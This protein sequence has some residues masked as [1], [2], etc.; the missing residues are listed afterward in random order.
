MPTSLL[1][2]KSAADTIKKMLP[3]AFAITGFLAFSYFIMILFVELFSMIF[4]QSAVANVVSYAISFIIS[5]F[6]T[7]PITLGIMR[8]FW[9]LTSGA[10]DSLLSCFYY[11]SSIE[12]YRISLSLTISQFVR[13]YLVQ[14]LL[15]LP[16]FIAENFNPLG[17][18]EENLFSDIYKN[19]F[20]NIFS[21]ISIIGSYITLWLFLRYFLAQ[22]LLF[23]NE[24]LT[25]NQAMALSFQMMKRRVWSLVG[26]YF[27][28]IGWLFLCFLVL[29]VFYVLP[30]MMLGLTVYARYLIAGHNLNLTKGGMN[31][32]GWTYNQ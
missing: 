25:A 1:I 20:L 15:S 6:F 13:I 8:Y 30:F 14:I 28:N 21:V 31:H 16:M 5:L 10:D 3:Q 9:R 12:K 2:R 32:Y 27:S 11:F 17:I 19:Y 26:F 22:F 29:P 18:F 23:N 4:G 24:E 7:S